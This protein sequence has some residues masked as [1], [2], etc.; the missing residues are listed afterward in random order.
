MPPSNSFPLDMKLRAN[1]TS[2]T[3]DTMQTL[4]TPQSVNDI[5]GCVGGYLG[6]H[7]QESKGKHEMKPQFLLPR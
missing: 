7:S 4:Y 3:M 5:P 2:R 1:T 6:R